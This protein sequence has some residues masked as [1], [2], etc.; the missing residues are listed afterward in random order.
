MMTVLMMSTW[1]SNDVVMAN[2]LTPASNQDFPMR[3][4][5]APDVYMYKQHCSF[6]PTTL[7][8]S[9]HECGGYIPH[10]IATQLTQRIKFAQRGVTLYETFQLTSEPGKTEAKLQTWVFAFTVPENDYTPGDIVTQYYRGTVSFITPTTP[11]HRQ[12]RKKSL[13]GV[14]R[15]SR[16]W[17][18]DVPRGLYPDELHTVINTL[19]NAIRSHPDYPAL[20][21]M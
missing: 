12:R 13:L 2:G 20:A 7:S 8:G 10:D 19:R 11:V 15:G 18:E 9:L 16:R 4:T 21:L 14:K 6:Y 1:C 5:S 3:F 17:I